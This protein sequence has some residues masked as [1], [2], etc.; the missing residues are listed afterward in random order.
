MIQLDR[1]DTQLLDDHSLLIRGGSELWQIELQRPAK[2]GRGQF[3]C[4]NA[5]N[6]G[7]RKLLV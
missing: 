5:I 3:L 7:H 4:R 6:N 2:F 1:I